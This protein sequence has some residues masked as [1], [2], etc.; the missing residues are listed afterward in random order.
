MQYFLLD[1][2]TINDSSSTGALIQGVEDCRLSNVT[3]DKT[4]LHGVQFDTVTNAY[5]DG[6]YIKDQP[7]RGIDAN[8]AVSGLTMSHSI[9]QITTDLGASNTSIVAGA[10]TRQTYIKSRELAIHLRQHL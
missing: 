10:S 5:L 9:L 2:D 1:G 8:T 6:C 3:I 4:G 7:N